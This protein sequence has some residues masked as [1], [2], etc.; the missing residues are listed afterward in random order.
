MVGWLRAAVY[1]SFALALALIVVLLSKQDISATTWGTVYT[2][3]LTSSAPYATGD[4]LAV[5][6]QASPHAN[7][8]FVGNS[9]APTG[10]QPATDSQL[11]D[12]AN[13]GNIVS[14]VTL[15]FINGPC[16]NPL[17]LKFAFMDATTDITH[18][19]DF[20]GTGNDLV[21]DDDG[22]TVVEAEDTNG[23][24]TYVDH[25]PSFL[26]SRYD[27]DGPAG[28][29]L[30]LRPR[31]R[32]ASTLQVL[33]GAPVTLLN[34]VIFS[35]GDLGDATKG[36]PGAVSV[37]EEAYGFVNFVELNNTTAAAAPSTITDFCT[38]LATTTT[39][40]G[41]TKGLMAVKT[42]VP[43]WEVAGFDKQ[44]Y[45]PAGT[46]NLAKLA[47]TDNDADGVTDD[48]CLYVPDP[49]VGFDY[50][51]N[52]TVEVANGED[53]AGDGANDNDADTVVDEGC[54]LLRAENP[55]PLTG[56]YGT[57]THLQR[58]YSQA[59]RDVDGDGRDNGVDVCPLVVDILPDGAGQAGDT[60]GD[61]INEACDPDDTV[62][63]PGSPA[64]DG[65]DN[66]G[67]NAVLTTNGLD[68]DGDT[69]IDEVGEGIDEDPVDNADN[70]GDTRLDEDGECKS[71]S[72]PPDEDQDCYSNRGDNCALLA[73]PGDDLDAT[74]PVPADLGEQID[75]IGDLCEAGADAPVAEAA[76]AD[77][78]DNDG[79][80]RVNDGCPQGAGAAE[81]AGVCAEA[82]PAPRSADNDFDSKIN[83]GCAA[84]GA[85]ETGIQCANNIDDDLGDAVEHPGT[86]RVNDGC[87]AVGGRPEVGAECQ[88]KIA[89]AADVDALINDGCPRAGG[90]AANGHYHADAPAAAYCIPDPD[91]A[92]DSDNNG[93]SDNDGDGW[94]DSTEDLL[95]SDKGL[96]GSTP[97]YLGLEYTALPDSGGVAAQICND[98][99]VYPG[100]AAT[101]ND[102]TGGANAADPGCNPANFA[103]DTDMDGV[104]D[105][106][107]NCMSADNPEQ[108]D[109]N[110][111][112]TGDDCEAS[113]NDGDGFDDLNEAWMGTDHTDDCADSTGDDAWPPDANKDG[114]ALVG[115]V[116][117]LFFNRIFATLDPLTA[118]YQLR[119]DAN[120]DGKI[121]VGDVILLFFNRIFQKCEK[122]VPVTNN[123]GA[124]VNYVEMEFSSKVIEIRQSVNVTDDNATPGNAADDV[125]WTKVGVSGNLI[126]FSRNSG[127][128]PDTA[129][130]K[131]QKLGA[132][133][134]QDG[135]INTREGL[136]L[137]RSATLKSGG[138]A[139]QVE[140]QGAGNK[141]REVR[142]AAGA[143]KTCMVIT[144]NKAIAEI[145]VKD[146]TSGAITHKHVQYAT[147]VVSITLATANG[148]T[149]RLMQAMD[150][151]GYTV[152]SIVFD[153]SC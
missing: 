148:D 91:G 83:D 146:L 62:A 99:A 3:T 114:Q 142:Q 85:A 75:Q 54:G 134:G 13:V 1:S 27:P 92:D 63:S 84:V 36:L 131:T 78:A 119:S 129:I 115:D 15:G 11:T 67:D 76:C 89:D 56:L 144:F 35:A 47:G 49:C 52:G 133:A 81:G 10:F 17:L 19:V 106:V 139:G 16:A 126:K 149:V 37:M 70:D 123:T 64:P 26:N 51:G 44:C 8:A 109:G 24:P 135:G 140:N 130:I 137:L 143:A 147:S 14:A 58:G 57:G 104:P 50:S 117:S 42:G 48:G 111:N 69:L 94:C 125:A 97:E 90:G 120:G 101:D 29:K 45:L 136:P 102:G 79:D 31:A 73:N 145:T 60:D 12:G 87:T 153:N 112:G 25:Y 2:A 128:A 95:G 127:S 22:D 18:T 96:A 141:P 23:L 105:T 122:I 118:N 4:G 93:N 38:S 107:D 80:T 72:G 150:L 6:S 121:L 20:V 66:D 5:Y 108:R 110:N 103:G 61:G 113:D 53:I 46:D 41:L 86:P 77:A 21:K 98:L 32:Y 30:P 152:T 39:L 71:T 100:G 138:A 74:L 9:A 40:T 65:I 55:A 28:A 7:F 59:I 68:D 33:S 82:S 43:P 116:I 124:A 34:F 132:A 88:N 151:D